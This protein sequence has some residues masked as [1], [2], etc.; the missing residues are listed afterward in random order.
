MMAWLVRRRRTIQRIRKAKAMSK[1]RRKMAPRAMPAI[2]SELRELLAEGDCVSVGPGMGISVPEG[3]VVEEPMT[4]VIIIIDI[5]V[6]DVVLLD[7][8]DVDE[9]VEL[10]EELE[11]SEVDVEVA[12]SVVSDWVGVFVVGGGGGGVLRVVETGGVVGIPVGLG[13][14]KVVVVNTVVTALGAM[15]VVTNTVREITAV[16]SPE[17]KTVVVVSTVT[18]GTVVAT[19]SW[20]G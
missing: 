17:T 16:L 14:K 5:I 13:K 19:T 18:A 15:V 7:D 1:K 4:E 10:N 20:R 2:W 8:I 11:L 9:I 6:S 12:G 3:S